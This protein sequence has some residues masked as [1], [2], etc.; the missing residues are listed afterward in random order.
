V[1][2]G[3]LAAGGYARLATNDDSYYA[4]SSTTRTAFTSAWYAR[5][6]SV[7]RELS[8]LTVLYRGRNT[9]TCSQSVALWNWA[10]G[11]W[12]GLDSRSV[13]TAEVKVAKGAG[14]TLSDYVSGPATDG[15]LRVR[16]RCT[17]T[18]GTFTVRADQLTVTYTAS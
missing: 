8:T 10:T 3:A 11:T 2:S 4:V 12:V 13:G 5:F 16:V 17:S 18:S 7:P 15:E 14:G 6:A 9:R 1:N